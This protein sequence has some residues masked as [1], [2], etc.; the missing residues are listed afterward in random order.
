MQYEYADFAKAVYESLKAAGSTDQTFEEWDNENFWTTEPPPE[1][2]TFCERVFVP[3]TGFENP[4]LLNGVE[5]AKLQLSCT[6]GA[7]ETFIQD[8]FYVDNKQYRTEEEA[9][10]AWDIM[11]SMEVVNA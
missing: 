6:G 1:D 10:A 3:C 9:R 2:M 11:R 5:Y 4:F 8:V 7:W